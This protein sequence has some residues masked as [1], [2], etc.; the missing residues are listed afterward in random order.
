MDYTIAILCHITKEEH[1]YFVTFP[2]KAAVARY[3]KHK[4]DKLLSIEP[5]WERLIAMSYIPFV[6]SDERYKAIQ[7]PYEPGD[8]NDFL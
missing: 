8:D 2:N 1:V 7:K 4:K 6:Q 3:F 5:G